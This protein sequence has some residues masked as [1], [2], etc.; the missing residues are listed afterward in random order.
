MHLPAT[1]P[2]MMLKDEAQASIAA[3]VYAGRIPLWWLPEQV[4]PAPQ[5]FA[6]HDPRMP[7]VRGGANV[8]VTQDAQGYS[9][10]AASPPAVETLMDAIRAFQ[11]HPPQI[12]E[13]LAG[14]NMTVTRNARGWL[15]DAAS[16]GASSPETLIQGIAPFLR[17]DPRIP[18]VLP[19]T[20]ITVTP[21]AR[22][23]V[24]DAII[25]QLIAGT[26]PYQRHHPAIPE[27]LAGA[28]ISIVRN[29]RGYVIT[30]A[31]TVF[32][33]TADQA[34]TAATLQN[35]TNMSFAV[36]ANTD[37]F[38]EFF[39]PYRSATATTGLG[40]AVT[41]PASPTD[42]CYNAEIPNLADSGGGDWQGQGTAS[43]DAIIAPNTPQ[44]NLSMLARL[45]GVLRNGANAGTLQLQAQNE[46]GTTDCTIKAGA[47]MRWQVI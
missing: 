17:H 46:T 38:F 28:G 43:A 14:T 25:E 29:A 31:P 27:V 18:E 16:G 39:V 19:G 26:L 9:V 35:V 41:C 2:M 12:P 4:S 42:I 22:G 32:K 45:Q 24:L 15:L 11:P 23:V 13:I 10:A 34:I 1:L 3:R 6:R 7:D 33:L 20:A 30:A 47:V 44:I 37:Y 8:T 5:I 36:A 21:N 40:L